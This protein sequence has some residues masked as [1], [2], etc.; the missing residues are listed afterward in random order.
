MSTLPHPRHASVGRAG[1]PR[2]WSKRLLVDVSHAIEQLALA[3]AGEPTL[4]IAMFQRP[5]YFMREV[6]VYRRIAALGATVVVG[7]VEEPPPAL[8]PGVAHV[9]LDA[10][11]PLAREWSVTVLTPARGATLVA[12]DTE[13]VAADAATLESGRQFDGMWSFLREEAYAQAVRLRGALR[14]RLDPATGRDVDG[15]LRAVAAVAGAQGEAGVDHAVRHLTQRLAVAHDRQDA[16][17]A[18]AD[19]RET[20][21][22]RHTGLRPASYLD[23]WLRGSTSGTVPIG[24]M[25]VRIPA[26]V[27]LRNRIGMRAEMA[28]RQLAGAAVAA[29]CGGADRAVGLSDGEFLLLLPGRN[30]ADLSAVHAALTAELHVA[31]TRFPFVDL[32]PSTASAVTRRRPLPVEQLAARARTAAPDQLI[33]A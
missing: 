23:G 3:G 29:H 18:R 26:L 8:P 7:V 12:T 6:E 33:S 1:R 19:E 14:E 4:V 17:R 15:V 24:L 11:E 27:G 2:S 5:A 28:A 22:D 31:A 20:E 9:V 10:D 21:R 30:A 32:S 16:L 25:V 13:T